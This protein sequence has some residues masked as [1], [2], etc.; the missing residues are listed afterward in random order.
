MCRYTE[1]AAEDWKDKRQE[2]DLFSCRNLER[3]GE[4]VG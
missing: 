4:I 1:E 3:E 2:G